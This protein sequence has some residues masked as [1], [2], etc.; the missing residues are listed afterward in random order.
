ML[1]TALIDVLL[2]IPRMIINLIPNFDFVFP[3]D[4]MRGL[5]SITYGIGYFLPV[6]E[7]M[8]ILIFSIVFK[9]GKIVM[10]I[11]YRIKSFIPTMGN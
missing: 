6:V 10:E 8:P 2:F 3:V 11:I 1:L 9:S 4:V 7:L 5:V